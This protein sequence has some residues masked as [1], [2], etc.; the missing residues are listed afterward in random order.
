[1]LLIATH[2]KII[3][4]KFIY[5]IFFK[6]PNILIYSLLK[7]YLTIKAD[8]ET[9]YPVNAMLTVNLLIWKTPNRSVSVET[10]L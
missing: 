10:L 3:L 7:C 1:M 6:T 8:M 2:K 5:T 9:F 4:Y